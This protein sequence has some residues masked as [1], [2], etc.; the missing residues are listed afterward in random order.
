MT[1]QVFSPSQFEREVNSEIYSIIDKRVG[2]PRLCMARKKFLPLFR[3]KIPIL[4]CKFEEW[5][6]FDEYLLLLGTHRV[7]G[8]K[9]FVATKLSKRGNS[10]HAYRLQQRL[11]FLR[12]YDDQFFSVRNFDTEHEVKTRLLWV[13]LTDNTQC[14]LNHAWKT[15]EH[16]LGLF[17]ANLRNLYGRISVLRF[18]QSSPDP[19]GKAYGYPHFHL[20][21]LFHTSEFTVF[22]QVKVNNHGLKELKYRVKEKYELEAQGKWHS[23]IDVQALSSSR[24]VHR[25]CA[26]YAQD[27][28][29]GESEKAA[30]N[31]AVLW[32]YQKRSFTV[33][34]DFREK[35]L[36][37]IRPLHN[38]KVSSMQV[39]LE[40]DELPEWTWEAVGIVSGFDL[41]SYGNPVVFLNWD[42]YSRLVLERKICPL[43][44][45]TPRDFPCRWEISSDTCEFVARRLVFEDGFWVT[46]V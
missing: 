31:N 13:T 6:D 30:V 34:E 36:E 17:L 27:V 29:S 22:P 39:S 15:C 16:E 24:A 33:S 4:V 9:K 28:M 18:T 42:D 40:G 26:K 2:R 8:V 3:E 12:E 10:V 32:L 45:E 44:D 43:R 38:S 35:Y 46:S 21:L 37:F 5:R 23:Y 7:T 20:V 19:K 11:G 41:D 14:S 1:L 25:Y